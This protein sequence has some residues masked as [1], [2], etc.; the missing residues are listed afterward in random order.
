[1]LETITNCHD[2]WLM[3]LKRKIIYIITDL[4]NNCTDFVLKN[5]KTKFIKKSITYSAASVWNKLPKSAKT[6]GIGVAKFKSIL[7]RRWALKNFVNILHYNTF[8]KLV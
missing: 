2:Q 8:Y 3:N 5:P 4:R 6:K 7:D 1:M